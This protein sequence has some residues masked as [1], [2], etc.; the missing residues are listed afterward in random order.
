MPK[1]YEQTKLL[2]TR[3]VGY[4]DIF[5]STDA[6][7]CKARYRQ[8]MK[9]IHPDRV[10]SHLRTEA[11][12]LS[13]K[14]SRLYETA[15]TSH[16]APPS[17]TSVGSVVMTSRRGTHT[18]TGEY[19][20]YCD[21]THGYRAV[22]AI[23]TD[24][25][26]TLVKVSETPRDNDLLQQEAAALKRLA[27][28]SGDEFARFYPTLV[29]SFQV[30]DGKRRLRANA[31]GWMEGFYNLDELRQ[32][33]PDG[34]DP[35]D[36]A[37]VWRRMVWALGG[38]HDIGLLHG[39]VLPQHVIVHPKMH[40]VLLVDWCYSTSGDGGTFPA[41]KAIVG[42][43]RGWYSPNVLA[44][45]ELHAQSD[46]VMAAR[47]MAWLL[48]GD[49]VSMTM[50]RRIPTHMQRYLIRITSGVATSGAF[51]LLSQFDTLLH[52]LGAP[53]YPRKYRELKL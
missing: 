50:P 43:R 24:K 12:E 23:G 41:L 21:M 16:L 10:P 38:A 46:L 14:L 30:A 25:L 1:Q 9:D 33:R 45:R 40:G 13:S 22:S 17:G 31:L 44:G 42:A 2:L 5:P 8:L 7:E 35:L 36:A 49:P 15:R 11:T 20:R 6:A 32:Y 47:T 4:R 26:E 53:Y 29:D 52:T 34:L 37:W 3:A 18:M 28:D 19:S 51:E 27:S 48:G 39:A